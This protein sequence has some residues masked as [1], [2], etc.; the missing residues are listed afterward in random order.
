MWLSFASGLTVIKIT[1]NINKKFNYFTLHSLTI[2][3]HI[4]IHLQSISAVISCL[5]DLLYHIYEFVLHVTVITVTLGIIII[6][7]T[8]DNSK[9][10]VGYF[11][12]FDVQRTHL[13]SSTINNVY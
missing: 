8:N 12:I 10:M 1:L 3:Y 2:V 11:D 9:N 6:K 4:N 5:C 13:S 7:D